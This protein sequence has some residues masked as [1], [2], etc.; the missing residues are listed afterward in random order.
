MKYTNYLV[1]GE[2]FNIDRITPDDDKYKSLSIIYLIPVAGVGLVLCTGLLPVVLMMDGARFTKANYI[3]YSRKIKKLK[4]YDKIHSVAEFLN[5][6]PK[7]ET[8]VK[9]AYNF[10]L[11][12]INNHSISPKQVFTDITNLLQ[13]EDFNNN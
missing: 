5:P 11:A 8:A 10:E 12:S 3:Y 13:L 6:K 2:A 4:H 7:I 1:N 9:Y